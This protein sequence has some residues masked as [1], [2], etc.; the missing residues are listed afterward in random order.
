MP[1]KNQKYQYN[2]QISE[3]KAFEYLDKYELIQK[4]LY[5]KNAGILPQ[6]EKKTEINIHQF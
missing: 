6:I 4:I 1:K 2:L 5:I 3:S